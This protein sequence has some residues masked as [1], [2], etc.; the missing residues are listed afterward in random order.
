MSRRRYLSTEISIDTAINRL[1]RTAGDFAVL[2]YTW[3]IPHADDDGILHG[4]AEE[5][6]LQVIPGRRDKSLADVTDALRA[7]Q[8]EGL[9][10]WDE[11]GRQVVFPYSSFYK[12]QTY[13]KPERRRGAEQQNAAKVAQDSVNRQSS[14]PNAANKR[15][16][17]QN[18]ASL[19]HSLS[20][21]VKHSH[22]EKEQ[23]T[24]ATPPTPQ[25]VAHRAMFGA[26]AR[27][28]GK[29]TPGTEHKKYEA[30]AKELVTAGADPA[31]IPH[32][33][34]AWG[35]INTVPPRVNSL[36]GNLTV[37][38]NAKSRPAVNGKN[39]HAPIPATEATIVEAYW[40]DVRYETTRWLPGA[41]EPTFVQ[42]VMDALASLGGWEAFMRDGAR[43]EAFVDALEGVTV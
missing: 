29:P 25:Q 3:M 21:P 11:E 31:E 33:C 18:V 28:F 43:R 10:E 35:W 8:K 22:S 20:H 6:I 1:A 32:L 4:D 23:P 13:I 27:A 36:A 16:T 30:A 5:I 7:M 2:L 15:K 12:Y 39:G 24:V 41:R 42:P 19:K 34:E 38:R 17:P 26:L 14:S 9:I 37:L 40:A